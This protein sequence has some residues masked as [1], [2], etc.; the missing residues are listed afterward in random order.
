MGKSI[1]LAIT[2]LN[3]SGALSVSMP[4]LCSGSFEVHQTP[5]LLSMLDPVRFRHSDIFKG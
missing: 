3:S 2:V 1:N 5:S 4:W